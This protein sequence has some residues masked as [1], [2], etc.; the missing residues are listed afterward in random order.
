M[1]VLAQNNATNKQTSATRQSAIL[2]NESTNKQTNKQ[3]N[4]TINVEEPAAMTVE[5]V[6]V[7]IVQLFQKI[8]HALAV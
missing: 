5:D 2:T 8:A 4:I 3:T 6:A 1:L 7:S